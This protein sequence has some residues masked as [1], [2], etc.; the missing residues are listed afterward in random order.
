[1]LNT[2][3]NGS[4][5]GSEASL[6]IVPASGIQI[7]GVHDTENKIV[8][9]FFSAI[10]KFPAKLVAASD[11]PE[12]IK[13]MADYVCDGVDD[14]EE[15]NTAL[16]EASMVVL[17]PGTY[18]ITDSIL[19]PSNRVLAG[20][21]KTATIVL[22]GDRSSDIYA[23]TNSDHTNGNSNIT[24]RDLVIDVNGVAD[25]GGCWEAI[26]FYY[27]SNSKLINLT[28][29][30]YVSRGISLLYSHYFKIKD[31]ELSVPFD[32]ADY[33]LPAGIYVSHSS[34][35]H[36]VGNTFGTPE[37]VKASIPILLYYAEKVFI[38]RNHFFQSY[39]YSIR[40]TYDLKDIS[41]KD[42]WFRGGSGEGDGADPTIYFYGTSDHPVC[43]VE[44]SG[45]RFNAEGLTNM[46]SYCIIIGSADV[47]YT[48]IHGNNFRN[49][50]RTG[51]VSDSGTGTRMRDNIALDGGWMADV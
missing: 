35:G 13:A 8:H 14:Q 39:A 5:I 41:I 20:I 48:M 30:N 33:W 51:E 22:N 47:Y 32:I 15:I 42:N 24:I 45:N 6:N 46:P 2:Y 29:K 40:A 16:Q 38:K 21:N 12:W 11:T 9:L 17:A 19:V 37:D 28:V 23:I 1:M 27:V 7:S 34:F 4:L 3:V 49:G 25:Q 50:A 36:I 10:Q 18:T 26:Y 31:C 43:D 44:I